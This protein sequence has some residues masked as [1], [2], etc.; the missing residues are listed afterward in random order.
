MSEKIEDVFYKP[1]QVSPTYRTATKVEELNEDV[2]EQVANS[3]KEIFGSNDVWGEGY[4]CSK[5]GKT[6]PLEGGHPAGCP[7]CKSNEIKEFYPTEELKARITADMEEERDIK[8]VMSLMEKGHEVVGFLWGASGPREKILDRLTKKFD[9]QEARSLRAALS[10][11]LNELGIEEKDWILSGDEL[12]IKKEHRRGATPVM[13]LAKLWLESGLDNNAKTAIFWTSKK[14]NIYEICMA[15]GFVPVFDTKDGLTY[16]VH[17]D[18]TPLVQA[19][20]GGESSFLK[21]MSKE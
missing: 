6:F 9:E 1:E 18:S 10:K 4:R 14:S 8:P 15:G 16:M 2:V 3:Y 7:E 13:T 19:M 21:F 17:P 11:K 5:C 12:G 20:K